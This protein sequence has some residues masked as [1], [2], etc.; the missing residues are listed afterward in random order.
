[1]PELVPSNDGLIIGHDK[2]VLSVSDPTTGY[3]AEIRF[4]KDLGSGTVLAHLS[5]PG[6]PLRNPSTV[7]FV[8][9][10]SAIY[11]LARDTNNPTLPVGLTRIDVPKTKDL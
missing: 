11:V 7:E 1:M 3:L 2:A 8:D 5:S 4:A 9:G 6:F 10:E